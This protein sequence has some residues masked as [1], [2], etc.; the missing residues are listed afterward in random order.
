MIGAL[1]N[2]ISGLS[3]YQSALNSESNNIANVNTVAYK[4]DQV[5]FADMMYQNGIGTGA[6][7]NKVEKDLSQGTFKD[8]GNSYD[9]AIN[10]EGYFTVQDINKDTFYTRSGNFKMGSEG[11]LQTVNGLSVMGLTMTDPIVTGTNSTVTTFGTTHTNFVASQTIVTEDKA[12]TINTKLTNYQDSAIQTGTTGTNYKTARANIIDIDALS[13]DYQNQL[14]KYAT[15]PIAGTAPT[16]YTSSA[17]FTPASIANNTDTISIVINNTKYLQ[18]FDTDAA[19]TLNKLSDQISNI[20][21]LAASVDSTS[22]I[23]TVNS[24]IPGKEVATQSAKINDTET[25]ITQTK[26]IEGTGLAAV[27]AS[28]LALKTAVEAANGEFLEISSSV[29]LKGTMLSDMQLKLDDLKL[30]DMSFGTMSVNNGNIYMTQGQNK[31]IVG[32]VATATFIDKL[33][34]NPEGNNLYSANKA[35]GEAILANNINDVLNN[36]LELSN[37]DLGEG[38]VNLM[39]YQRSFEANSKSITT[40]DEFLKTAIQLKK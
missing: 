11:T 16:T 27:T 34:L 12:E 5:S 13:T 19:T 25:P 22:G 30:S 26:A 20:K 23:L 39:I 9:M 10:G 29:D 28:Q 1:Y 40:S 35:S 18:S 8:T 15:N 17:T 14:S 37:A 3:V 24:L 21:G 4:A 38:L 7:L 6:S 2:G 32:T 33:S 31:F 36:K